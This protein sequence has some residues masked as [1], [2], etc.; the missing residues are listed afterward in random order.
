MGQKDFVNSEDALAAFS[1]SKVKA[2]TQAIKAQYSNWELV[3]Y[4]E[5]HTYL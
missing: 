4:L 2:T 5:L 3:A 1:A